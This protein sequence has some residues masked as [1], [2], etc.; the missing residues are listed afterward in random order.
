[1]NRFGSW[2]R[3]VPL[4]ATASKALHY[5]AIKNF[6]AYFFCRC[7]YPSGVQFTEEQSKQS[8]NALKAVAF[9]KSRVGVLLKAARERLGAK[10]KDVE[11]ASGISASHIWNIETGKKDVTVERMLRLA[12]FYGFNPGLLLET[13]FLVD[14]AP[15]VTSTATDP[16][17]LELVKRGRKSGARRG[18]L[19]AEYVVGCAVIFT[20]LLRSSQPMLLIENFPW[21]NFVVKNRFRVKATKLALHMSPNE[22]MLTCVNLVAKPLTTLRAFELHDEA[23]AEDFIASADHGR[24]PFQLPWNPVPQPLLDFL[25]PFK[26]EPH[27]LEERRFLNS[28]RDRANQKTKTASKKSG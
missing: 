23:E 7:Y 24:L 4:I 28:L 10:L 14:R 26:L 22:R 21:P 12:C 27:T 25:E 6:V 20:Y 8:V 5:S 18:E 17:F 16:E 13:G 2:L 11:S 19:L 9:D 3:G 1:V 15:F